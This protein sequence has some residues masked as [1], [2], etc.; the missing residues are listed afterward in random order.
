[1]PCSVNDS[2]PSLPIFPPRPAVEPSSE[3]P[4]FAHRG[5]THRGQPAGRAISFVGRGR[6]PVHLA[7]HSS[8]GCSAV[9]CTT[10]TATFDEA[11]LGAPTHAPAATSESP[12][13]FLF[14]PPLPALHPALARKEHGPLHKTTLFLPSPICCASLQPVARPLLL[15]VVNAKC[16]PTSV[17]LVSSWPP[18]RGTEFLPSAHPLVTICSGRRKCIAVAGAPRGALLTHQA[19]VYNAHGR[20][21]CSPASAGV[22]VFSASACTPASISACTPAQQK[23]GP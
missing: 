18:I 17:P 21:Y 11:A 7:F 23:Q 12:D 8:G 16:P 3:R 13:C 4:P 2:S 15:P 6:P 20:R 5:L 19:P 22:L 9:H 1:M 10:R 14:A